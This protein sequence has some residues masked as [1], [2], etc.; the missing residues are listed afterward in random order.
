MRRL[1]RLLLIGLAVLAI[2]EAMSQVFPI[3]SGPSRTPDRSLSTIFNLV[4][5]G[6]SAL[7]LARIGRN[8]R[9]WTLAFCIILMISV[10]IAGIVVDE[11]DPVMMALFVLII[12][13]A[14]TVPW[15]ARWQAALGLIALGSF[16]VNA[17]TGVIEKNDLQ[18]WL[19]LTALMAF[20]V[21][22]AALK[23][24]LSSSTVAD[25]GLG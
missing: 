10:T 14:V 3:I 8:W 24:Y 21:S 2:F 16:T 12:T 18:Q 22:F 20:A 1:R 7:S 15:N 6:V 17:L 4:L 23:D 11:D 19:I 5:I 9:W 25:R 13:S